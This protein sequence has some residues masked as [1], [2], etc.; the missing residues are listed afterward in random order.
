MKKEEAKPKPEADTHLVFVYGTLKKGFYNNKVW[1]PDATKIGDDSIG[2]YVMLDLGPY[3]A[4][5][6]VDFVGAHGAFGVTGELW[7]VPHDSYMQVKEMEEGAG[8][9]AVQATTDK[10]RKVEVFAMHVFPEGNYSWVRKGKVEI[11]ERDVI[12]F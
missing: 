8:Y 9:T 10:G 12:P 2:G 3:P 4:I 5:A 7:E 1:F 11:T 6:K